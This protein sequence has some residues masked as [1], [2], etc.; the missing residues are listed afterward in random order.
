MKTTKR[1]EQAVKSLYNAFNDNKLNAFDYDSCA[2]RVISSSEDWAGM[3]AL[4]RKNKF[5]SFEPALG[6]QCYP[7]EGNYTQEE[8]YQI[9]KAFLKAW[10]GSTKKEKKSRERQFKGLENVI[11]YLARLDNIKNPMDYTNLF[12]PKNK[13]KKIYPKSLF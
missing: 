11:K 2:V 8:Y 13:H 10:E 12:L 1:F 6:I 9:E 5:I 4:Y 3:A 7:E